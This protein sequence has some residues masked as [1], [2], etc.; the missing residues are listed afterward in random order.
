MTLY[1]FLAYCIAVG[2]LAAILQGIIHMSVELD[3]LAAAV[4]SVSAAADVAIAKI[5]ALPAG[6]DPA[7][8]QAQADAVNAVVA[9][10]QAAVA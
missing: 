3:N 8:V 2:F 4:A 10:L 9:K 1:P 7:A 6:V 5:G